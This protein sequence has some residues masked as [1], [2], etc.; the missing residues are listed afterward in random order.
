M[1]RPE[2][3]SRLRVD[4]NDAVAWGELEA[5]VRRWARATL[6]EHGPDLVEDAVADTCTRVV[7]D[8]GDARGADTFAGFA[9][10]KFLN[11]RKAAIA[12]IR[13]P[14]VRLDDELELPAPL[15]D[16]P[17][18]RWDALYEVLDRCLE[19]LPRRDRLAVQLRYYEDAQ[20]ARIAQALQVTEG[21]A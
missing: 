9:K 7:L 13:Q 20:A 11:A 17:E 1:D 12:W 8:L 5:R 10:G 14:V 6:G 19:R 21:N 16:R 15:V 2:I 4:R 18:S 3:Y